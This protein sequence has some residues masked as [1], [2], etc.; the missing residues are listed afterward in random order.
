MI[1]NTGVDVQITDGFFM[2]GDRDPIDYEEGFTKTNF[3]TG[4]AGENWSVLLYGKNVFDKVTPQG[5][6][7]IPLASGSHAQYVLPGAVWGATLNYS[8]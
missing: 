6:F 2:T 7:D 8:F 3:R 4:L 5:A 1:W